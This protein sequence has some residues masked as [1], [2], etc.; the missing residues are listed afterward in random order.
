MSRNRTEAGLEP[1]FGANLR[2]ISWGPAGGIS[3][4]MMDAVSGPAGLPEQERQ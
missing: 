2:K 4:P 1:V 3:L